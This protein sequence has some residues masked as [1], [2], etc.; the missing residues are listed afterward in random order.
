ML[1]IYRRDTFRV[2]LACFCFILPVPAQT[3][4]A[5]AKD[6]S[7]DGGTSIIGTHSAPGTIEPKWRLKPGTREYAIDIS[8]A[9]MQ[10]TF[11]SGRKEYNTDGRKF[12]MASIRFGWVIGTVRGVTYEYALEVIP[13]AFAVKNDVARRG[14]PATSVVKETTYAFGF[15]PVSFRFIFMPERR[16][17]PYLRVG[18]GLIFSGKP[19]PVPGSTTYNFIGDFGGGLIYHLS[20]KKT[21]NLGYRYFHISNM[22]IGELN[23]GYNANVFSVGYSFFSK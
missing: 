23:P 1:R 19:I 12:A 9:P 7:G 6:A 2:L 11:F 21:I 5:N 10:P 13:V 17:K 8:Y 22:N 15:Q 16:I 3:S 20:P 14:T 4:L 18:V